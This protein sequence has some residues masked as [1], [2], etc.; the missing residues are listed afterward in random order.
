MP[1]LTIYTQNA[2]A[3]GASASVLAI[4]AAIATYSP[5]YSVRFPFIGII[6]LKHM[7]VILKV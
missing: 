2:Q 3:L 5:N 4:V 6:K 7:L 1:A